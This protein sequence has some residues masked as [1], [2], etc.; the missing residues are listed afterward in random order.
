MIADERNDCLNSNPI[1]PQTITQIA[2]NGNHTEYICSIDRYRLMAQPINSPASAAF[3]SGEQLRLSQYPL[4]DS[5]AIGECRWV[6]ETGWC[7]KFNGYDGVGA[8]IFG[9]PGLAG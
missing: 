6:S 3:I 2:V 7:L 1:R 9:P 4:D 5:I 8:V